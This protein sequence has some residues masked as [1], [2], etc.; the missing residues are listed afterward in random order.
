M[1]NIKDYT[2]SYGSQHKKESEGLDN[3]VFCKRMRHTL[4]KAEEWIAVIG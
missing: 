2:N 3:L 1:E 4:S